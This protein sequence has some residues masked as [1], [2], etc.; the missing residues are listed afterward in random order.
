MRGT[1]EIQTESSDHLDFDYENDENDEG[2]GKN[3]NKF[4]YECKTIFGST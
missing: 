1:A 4:I 3:E 2:N